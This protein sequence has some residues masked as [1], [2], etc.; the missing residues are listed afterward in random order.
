VSTLP[1][2]P[3]HFWEYLARNALYLCHTKLGAVYELQASFRYSFGA[4][5]SRFGLADLRNLG[6][7]DTQRPEPTS[8]DISAETHST[9]AAP[10][11]TWFMS[12]GFHFD[13]V[14]VPLYSGLASS[15]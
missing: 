7:V 2:A 4:A 5:R 12:L 14:L 1:H 15:T 8:A 3:R 9:R 10:N 11:L 6:R 13:A